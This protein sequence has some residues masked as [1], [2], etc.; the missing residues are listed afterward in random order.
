MEISQS[1]GVSEFSGIYLRYNPLGVLGLSYSAL[2]YF[3][4]TLKYDLGVIYLRKSTVSHP[5]KDTD[6]ISYV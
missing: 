6:R 2:S 1:S 4:T 5:W 3:L